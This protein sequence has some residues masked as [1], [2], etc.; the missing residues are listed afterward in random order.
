MFGSRA[1]D[2]DVK[3][4]SSTILSLYLSHTH[5]RTHISNNNDT[6]ALKW[7]RVGERDSFPFAHR[8]NNADWSSLERHT[9]AIMADQT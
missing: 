5:A 1:R 6:F 9:T 4:Q 3:G 2:D 8:V 7:N